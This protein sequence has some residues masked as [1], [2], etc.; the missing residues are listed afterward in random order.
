MN[1]FRL[2]TYLTSNTGI[3]PFITEE[4]LLHCKMK[5]YKKG[6][7]LLSPGEKC[8]DSFFVEKGLLR[9][10]TIDSKGKEHVLQFAPE[11]WFMT[12]R[13]S[14]Y[15]KQTS[16][17]YIQAL[18]DTD[19]FLISEELI[20]QLSKSNPAFTEFNNKLLHNHIKQLQKRIIQLQS[21]SAE[22]RYLD[23]IQ[24]YPDLL[25]RVSQVL[26]ASYLGITPESLSRVRKELAKRNHKQHF[27][28]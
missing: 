10:Y 7:F 5:Q 24:I 21:A 27:L 13:D 17:Y 19:V 15:F 11:N 3:D 23:F 8:Y 22:E 12:D 26:I 9:Q 2:T 16:N 18:E 20:L 28:S 6:D 1:N 25:L 4:L 14:V